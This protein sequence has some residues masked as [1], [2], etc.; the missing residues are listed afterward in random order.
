MSFAG[1]GDDGGPVVA[2]LASTID[3]GT[4][5]RRTAIHILNGKKCDHRDNKAQPFCEWVPPEMSG[6]FFF[7]TV[8]SL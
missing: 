6:L 8:T 4:S 2:N 3:Y 7:L 5:N 1:L